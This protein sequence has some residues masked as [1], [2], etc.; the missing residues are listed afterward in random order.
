MSEG[1]QGRSLAVQLKQLSQVLKIPTRILRYVVD[2]G[3]VPDIKPMGDGPFV[4]REFT[5]D[6][7]FNIALAAVLHSHGFK[8]QVINTV[9]KKAIGQ[10][11][12]GRSAVT[13]DFTGENPVQLRMNVAGLLKQITKLDKES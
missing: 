1:T 2:Q 11:D 5:R 6:D 7:A 9:L 8:A 12:S 3:L 13:V 10:L 4:P